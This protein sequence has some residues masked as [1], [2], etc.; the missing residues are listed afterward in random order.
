MV[1][2]FTEVEKKEV[3][4]MTQSNPSPQLPPVP[5]GQLLKTAAADPK[6]TNI[7]LLVVVLCMSG[8]MPDQFST[9]CGVWYGRASS[10]EDHIG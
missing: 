10:R 4:A 5:V 6:T 3:I 7:L 1:N 8:L 2:G 9:L